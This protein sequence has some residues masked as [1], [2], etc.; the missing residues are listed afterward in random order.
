MSGVFV[1]VAVEAD[2]AVKTGRK[3]KHHV[4]SRGETLVGLSCRPSDGR[5]RVIGSRITFTEPDEGVR[6]NGV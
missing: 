3:Q 5:W 4:T 6:L 1:S 2:T